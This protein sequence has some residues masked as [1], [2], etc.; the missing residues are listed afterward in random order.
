MFDRSKFQVSFLILLLLGIL[1]GCATIVKGTTQS[2]PVAS[3]PSRADVWV[4]G[5]LRG[6]T[7]VDLELKRKRN[8]LVTI[9][10]AGHQSK[11]VPVVKDVGGAVWGNILLGGLIGWGVDATSGAQNNLNPKSISV[12]L[13]PSIE[14]SAA[15]QETQRQ[16]TFVQKLNELDELAE[17]QKVTEEEYVRMRNA[18][19]KEYYPEMVTP[20]AE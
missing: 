3:D 7:P 1:P 11:S 10:K 8:H 6:R 5:N 4:D 15:K 17:N 13:E 16:A 12:K 2:I 19:F 9:E 20:P 14:K 18:L